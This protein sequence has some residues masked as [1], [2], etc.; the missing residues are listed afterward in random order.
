MESALGFKER[1]AEDVVRSSFMLTRHHVL[2]LQTAV[3]TFMCSAI[4]AFCRLDQRQGHALF[5]TYRY[6]PW[7]LTYTC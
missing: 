3:L 6:E 4:D 1:V 7:I 2:Q 5:C